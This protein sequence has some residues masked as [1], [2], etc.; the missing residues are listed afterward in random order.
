MANLYRNFAGTA[1][2]CKECLIVKHRTALIED[3][4]QDYYNKKH[5]LTPESI[6]KPEPQSTLLSATTRLNS[7]KIIQFLRQQIEQQA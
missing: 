7:S 2:L 5:P 4:C 1:A 3:L 6:V